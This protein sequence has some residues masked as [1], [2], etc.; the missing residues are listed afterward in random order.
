MT[1]FRRNAVPNPRQKLCLSLLLPLDHRSRLFEC[2][3][4]VPKMYTVAQIYCAGHHHAG[5]KEASSS[6]KSAMVHIKFPCRILMLKIHRNIL[7]QLRCSSIFRT[8]HSPTN[9][10]GGDSV[11]LDVGFQGTNNTYSVY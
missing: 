1:A 4:S 5:T 2:Q 7:S 9:A 11:V 6:K 3:M 10:L 8:T